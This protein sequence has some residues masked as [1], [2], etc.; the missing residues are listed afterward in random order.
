MN[1]KYVIFVDICKIV[2]NVYKNIFPETQTKFKYTYT[3]A[4]N[5][6]AIIHV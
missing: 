6:P 1:L 3:Q 2:T 4:E 5:F